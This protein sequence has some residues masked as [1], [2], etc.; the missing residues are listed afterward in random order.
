MKVSFHRNGFWTHITFPKGC[1]RGVDQHGKLWFIR[2]NRTI[3]N[4]A[5]NIVVRKY[6]SEPLKERRLV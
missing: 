2:G 3:E 6:F 4:E 1:S 5:G